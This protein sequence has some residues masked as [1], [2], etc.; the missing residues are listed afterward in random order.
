MLDWLP[1]DVLAIIVSGLEARARF[2]ALATC[3]AL[4]RVLRTTRWPLLRLTLGRRCA[5]WP[6]AL[7][8]LH[9]AQ[10]RAATLYAPRAS[11]L[12]V[13][14]SERA[15]ATRLAHLLRRAARTVRSLRLVQVPPQAWLQLR[16]ASQLRGLHLEWSGPRAIHWMETGVLR[17]LPALR[18][19]TLPARF[20]THLAPRDEV[21]RLRLH[22]SRDFRAASDAGTLEAVAS[23][24][25]MLRHLHL[26]CYRHVAL[27]RTPPT[28]PHVVDLQ[29]DRFITYAVTPSWRTREISTHLGGLCDM[30]PALQ[31]LRITL[32]SVVSVDGALGH[33][34]ARR[35]DLKIVVEGGRPGPLRH[36]GILRL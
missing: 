21:D 2:A 33:V 31:T 26:D 22:S 20:A 19:L 9:E 34:F 25:P 6:D 30:L 7:P 4:R 1:D 27:E 28:L 5:Y 36:A 17:H 3:A 8:V 35:K 12:W 16:T 24:F 18:S 11:V 10:W 15:D 32:A 14:G 13:L 29:C 23:A